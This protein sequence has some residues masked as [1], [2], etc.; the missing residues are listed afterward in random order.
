M[1]E[2]ADPLKKLEE[3]RIL[4]EGDK[5]KFV[6]YVERLEL[7]IPKVTASNQKLKE[8]IEAVERELAELTAEKQ[9]LQEA[10][11]RQGLTPADIDRMNNDREKLSKSLSLISSKITE[12]KIQLA[13]RE[14]EA[15]SKLEALERS[16]S[17]YNS[18]AYQIG[19]VPSLSRNAEG[20]DFELLILPTQTP[21]TSCSRTRSDTSQLSYLIA[22]SGMI[23]S[24]LSTGSD[25]RLEH[26][27][28]RLRT[29]LSRLKS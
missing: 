10:V 6:T 14:S 27:F 8:E 2:S 22:I 1:D 13:E 9:S 16:V 21:K 4:L 23:L 26:E 11:D 18:L 17:R 15:S 5:Q 7:R 29:K 20:K 25:K 3:T 24:R 12:A 28:T 19:I